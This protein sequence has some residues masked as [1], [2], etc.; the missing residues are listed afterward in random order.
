[1]SLLPKSSFSNFWINQRVF[2]RLNAF[3]LMNF[4]SACIINRI[5]DVELVKDAKVGLT[6]LQLQKELSQSGE[7]KTEVSRKIELCQHFTITKNLK[8]IYDTVFCLLFRFCWALAQLM[9]AFKETQP[10]DVLLQDPESGL[11][12]VWKL[13]GILFE[14]LGTACSDI[15]R[16]EEW[17]GCKGLVRDL[18]YI[19]KSSFGQF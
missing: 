16:E 8:E 15:Q 4:L 1:M 19:R 18:L 14:A 10:I 7:R 17:S 3:E 13:K 2:W 9:K 5:F 12:V 6:P 11:Q